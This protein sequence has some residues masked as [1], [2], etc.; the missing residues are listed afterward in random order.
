MSDYIDEEELAAFEEKERVK[1]LELRKQIALRVE[2]IPP[3]SLLKTTFTHDPE[4]DPSLSTFVSVNG[5]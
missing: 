2:A 3:H 1:D 5:E 4:P